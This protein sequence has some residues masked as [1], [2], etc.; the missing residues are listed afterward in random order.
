MRTYITSVLMLFSIGE[1]FTQEDIKQQYK[2][3]AAYNESSASNSG[4]VILINNKKNDLLKVQLKPEIICRS[5]SKKK[6]IILSI[7]FDKTV[8]FDKQNTLNVSVDEEQSTL[9]KKEYE[10][11]KGI[12]DKLITDN[13]GIHEIVI[14]FGPNLE[15]E[16]AKKKIFLVLN[17]TTPDK[18]IYR[19][20]LI[21][22]VT[23][24]NDSLNNFRYLAYIGGK[25]GQI[26]HKFS[27]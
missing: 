11:T 1:A 23:S 24:E 6:S 9:P 12:K 3:P 22:T 27:A 21:L 16:T 8:L 25:N 2:L 13:D 26:D 20:F 19:D 4:N 18:K 15:N 7:Q 10:I 14:T 5:P 17:I